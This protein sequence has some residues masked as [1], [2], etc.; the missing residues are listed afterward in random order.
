[1]SEQRYDDWQTPD[2][3]DPDRATHVLAH[4]SDTHLTSPGV[5]YNGVLD[6]DAALD[7]AV[8]VLRDAALDAV[9][10]SGDLTDTGDPTAYRRLAG[11][12]ESI[13]TPGNAPLTIYATG[14][15]DVRTEF[16]RQLLHRDG[17]E[18]LLQVHTVRGL[19]VIVLDSTIVGAGHGRLTEPHLAE[20]RA[21]L[22]STAPAGTILVLHHAP[23]PPPSPLLS[24]FAA[25]EG[26]DVRMIL[27]GHHH[28]ARSAMLG[29]VPVAVAGSTTIRTDPLAPA[30]HERT[31]ASGSFNLIEV[32]PDTIVS[33]VIPVDGADGV[34]DLDSSGCRS[35]IQATRST[36][37]RPDFRWTPIWSGGQPTIG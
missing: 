25:I 1:V 28:L 29:T 34:F 32:Y 6:A 35:I 16:H 7:R 26:T 23:V 37:R 33:S 10:L 31:L 24:Y 22:R 2:G 14:N 11:A 8:A 30:G 3:S 17:T 15:H 18:P 9:V 5:R 13:A 36:D 27:A 20:L 19:R 21:E 12:V 4:L